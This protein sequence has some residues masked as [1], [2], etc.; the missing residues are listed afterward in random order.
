MKKCLFLVIVLPQIVAA[1]M[2][3]SLQ[4]FREAVMEYSNE[5]KAARSMEGAGHLLTRAA[6]AA[7][8]PSLDL[9]ASADY[10]LRDDSEYLASPI[11]NYNYQAA[12]TLQQII[13]GGGAATASYRIAS[14]NERMAAADV[15]LRTE[16]VLHAAEVAYWTLSASVEQLAVARRYVEIVAGLHDV[17]QNRY[18]DGYVAKNDLLMVQTRLNEARMQFTRAEQYHTLSQQTL[19]SLL[20]YESDIDFRPSDSITAPVVLPPDEGLMAALAGRAEYERA[21]L[22]VELRNHEAD[23]VR[24]GFNPQIALGL[25]ARLTT[26]AMN[27]S[28]SADIDG[29]VFANLSVP[30][31]RWGERRS[32]VAAAGHAVTAGEHERLAVQD[33]ISLEIG[34]AL[35][36]MHATARLLETASANLR[37]ASESLSLNTF[38]YTEGRLA[39][40]DVLQSQLSWIQAYTAYVDALCGQKLSIA[41]YRMAVGSNDHPFPLSATP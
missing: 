41:A 25:S 27:T 33:R 22:E 5:V 15:E 36:D 13:W 28:G 4:E 26:E 11:K 7:M 39:I 20:G 18:D 3:L 38:A 35:T 8:F 34:Q 12:L 1:Q 30:L 19:G 21:C 10:V 2:T 37:T 9:A 40:L 6:R 14:V 31:F 29:V 16:Q 17:V 23:L 32:S 24:A